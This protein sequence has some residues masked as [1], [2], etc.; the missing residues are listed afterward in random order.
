[1][2]AL[3]SNPITASYIVIWVFIQLF[4]KQ[5]LN[6]L[7]YID[8]ESHGSHLYHRSGPRPR[9]T[10][11]VVPE[12]D[13]AEAAL[14]PVKTLAALFD[15]FSERRLIES[16]IPSAAESAPQFIPTDFAEIKGWEHH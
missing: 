1:M 16:H 6:S 13:A 12:T 4:C 2:M 11:I 9:Y 14:I 5:A 15:H 3:G 8:F 10:R 7:D